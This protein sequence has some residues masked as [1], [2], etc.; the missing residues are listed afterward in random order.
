MKY[1]LFA[2][3][4]AAACLLGACGPSS[5]PPRSQLVGT[6]VDS[7]AQATLR[8][9]NDGTAH[10]SNWPTSKILDVDDERR[11]STSGRWDY[12]TEPGQG[13]WS[14]SLWPLNLDVDPIHRDAGFDPSKLND[15]EYGWC[16]WDRC[17]VAVRGDP[18]TGDEL[19][20]R[21]S[22]SPK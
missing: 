14:G 7:N 1:G 2:A 8:L 13:T 22:P 15:F 11:V 5:Q 4:A 19:V 17:V 6:W 18:D 21:K 3:M 10:L 20:F 9:D 12:R 16:G